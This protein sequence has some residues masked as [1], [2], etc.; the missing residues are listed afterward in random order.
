MKRYVF[1]YFS[2]V[3]PKDVEIIF[4]RYGRPAGL[5]YVTFSDYE[6]AQKAVDEKD[7]KHLGPRYL[8]LSIAG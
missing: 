6:V 3:E 5:A 8:E 4:N 7:G 2:Q 1:I